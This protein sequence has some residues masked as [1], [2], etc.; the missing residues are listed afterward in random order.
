MKWT[1]PLKILKVLKN[2]IRP[3][4]R[5]LI[6]CLHLKMTQYKMTRKRRTR[7]IR[8]IRYITSLETRYPSTLSSKEK[9]WKRKHIRN[10]MWKS[11]QP[12]IKSIIIL[13]FRQ[14]KISHTLTYFDGV[15]I[16]LLI[17]YFYSSVSKV[18]KFS[19]N[20]FDTLPEVL[21]SSQ[22]STFKIKMKARPTN[23]LNSSV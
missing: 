23:I 22:R 11:W 16:R 10:M 6:L 18:P 13:N 4:Q 21:T 20:I 2:S 15:S 12:R 5:F 9:K 7:S 14:R 17:S 8:S 3:I 1:L 19:L